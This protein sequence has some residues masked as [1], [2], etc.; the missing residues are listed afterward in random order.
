[1]ERLFADHLGTTIAKRYAEIRL[2]RAR[3]LLQQSTL[4]VA[5]V[6]VACGFV[7][8]SHF[9]RVYKARFGVRP[10]QE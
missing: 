10:R 4:S 2:K 3:T 6:A 8:T 5:E 7:S 1:L 9:S